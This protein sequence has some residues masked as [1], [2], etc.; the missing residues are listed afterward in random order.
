MERYWKDERLFRAMATT[1]LEV[2]TATDGFY[3]I[4]KAVN[5]LARLWIVNGPTE[6]ELWEFAG[7]ANPGSIRIVGVE[8]ISFSTTGGQVKSETS[9]AASTPSER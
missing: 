4:M 7:E 2:L 3:G 5:G 6:G 1:C 8:A 9:I